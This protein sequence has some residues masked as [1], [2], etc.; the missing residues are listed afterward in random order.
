MV[1]L[2]MSIYIE[3]FTKLASE[4]WNNQSDQVQQ[5]RR[6][7]AFSGATAGLGAITASFKLPMVRKK[8][9]NYMIPNLLV[10]V[11]MTL[12]FL[13]LHGIILFI[14]YLI[15][16]VGWAISPP[17]L[18]STFQFAIWIQIGLWST[19]LSN[20]FYNSAEDCFYSRL[21]DVDHQGLIQV[22]RWEENWSFLS[23]TWTSFKRT[24]K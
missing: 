12:A 8:A 5:W 3:K 7:D 13:V 24:I 10:M 15:G 14:C 16:L 1:R 19:L 22:H 23:R 2:R 20:M 21:N 17:T 18:L 9:W 4:A 11:S 6:G